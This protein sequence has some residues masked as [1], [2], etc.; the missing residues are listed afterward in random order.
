MFIKALIEGVDR[1][2]HGGKHY[3][4][5]NGIADVPE[6]VRSE[7]VSHTH[8]QDATDE[9]DKKTLSALEKANKAAEKDNA[10]VDA[11]KEPVDLEKK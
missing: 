8:W 11:A 9:I 2:I 3:P 1:L 10:A 7:V 6:E 4:V 5:I